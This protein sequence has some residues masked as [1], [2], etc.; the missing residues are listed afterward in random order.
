METADESVNRGASTSTAAV[1]EDKKKNQ[2]WIEKYRPQKFEEIMGKKSSIRPRLALIHF[3]SGNEET[4]S[5]LAVFA[6]QG[7]TPNIIIA[8]S[9][10]LLSL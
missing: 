8:V 5:R 9:S 4:V 7:N 3:S 1:I 10:L 6:T 2:P